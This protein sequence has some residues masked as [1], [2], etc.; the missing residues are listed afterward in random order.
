MGKGFLTT[1][2]LFWKRSN[3]LGQGLG[4][5]F[6]GLVH[7]H[8]CCGCGALLMGS[9]PAFTLGLGFRVSGLNPKL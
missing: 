3:G 2:Q 4:S 7:V 1:P 9:S 8:L 5:H 6:W